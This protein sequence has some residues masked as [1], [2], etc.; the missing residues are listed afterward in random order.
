MS[1]KSR[2]ALEVVRAEKKA[3]L[4]GDLRFIK[5]QLADLDHQIK[6]SLQ[7]TEKY[8]SFRDH[9]VKLKTKKDLL[10]RESESLSEKIKDLAGGK[11][12][13]PKRT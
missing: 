12:E 3:S 11:T 9:L 6:K 2:G 7:G 10:E 1:K 5:K 13:P 4:E 8:Q